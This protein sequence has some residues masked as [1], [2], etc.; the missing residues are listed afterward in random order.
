LSKY[1]SSKR[2]LYRVVWSRSL[3]ATAD[4]FSL[5]KGGCAEPAVEA[6]AEV[7]LDDADNDPDGLANPVARDMLLRMPGVAPGNVAPLMEA[8]GSLAGLAEL[9]LA[10]LR[11]A[12]GTS[13]GKALY[14]F[15]HAPYPVS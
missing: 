2:F 14:E 15:L 9:D 5:L 12:V 8:A 13:G 6:A 11:R 3:H 7:G 4:M 1:L 10:T